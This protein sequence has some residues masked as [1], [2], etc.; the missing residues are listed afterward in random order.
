M[1]GQ[2]WLGRHGWA[3]MA[4]HEVKLDWDDGKDTALVIV[5]IALINSSMNTV[6]FFTQNHKC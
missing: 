3:G 4:G 5:L 6:L 2:A 1:A